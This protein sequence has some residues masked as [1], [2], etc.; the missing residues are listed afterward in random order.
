MAGARVV[1]HR[2][3]KHE[4]LTRSTGMLYY[5]PCWLWTFGHVRPCRTASP[6]VISPGTK[7]HLTVAAMNAKDR[8][9]RFPV[10]KSVAVVW[11]A[12]GHM[13]RFA[14]TTRDISQ[15]GVFFYADFRP[16]E[17]SSLQLMLT[18]PAEVTQAESVP[19]TCR[20][21]V[22]RVVPDSDGSRVG[23]AVAIEALYPM[24][25]A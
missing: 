9:P 11:S 17:G 14:G 3:R 1:R 16:D 24:A 2:C 25:M 23:I 4:R 22:V 13:H 20:G 7:L 6:S 5:L 18:L 8:A 19:V 15:T 12:Q 10:E 21:R